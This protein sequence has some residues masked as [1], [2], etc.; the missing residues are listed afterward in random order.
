M[1]CQVTTSLSDELEVYLVIL[2][3][4]IIVL[5]FSF[6]Y[7]LLLNRTVAIIGTGDMGDSLGPRFG[8]DTRDSRGS[9]GVPGNSIAQRSSTKLGWQRNFATRVK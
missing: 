4:Q 7:D 9:P 2:G 5:K 3:F 1:G 6:S 8:R